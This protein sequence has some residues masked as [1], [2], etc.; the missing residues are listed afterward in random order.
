MQIGKIR[1]GGMPL[2]REWNALADRYNSGSFGRSGSGK[3]APVRI[4]GKNISGTD[5]KRFDCMAIEGVS[6]DLDADG[7]VDLV[8]ELQDGSSS[9]AT[10]ILVDPIE[11]QQ[12]GEIIV[13]GLAIAKVAAGTATHEYAI[14]SS[15]G[16]LTPQEETSD[17]R[18]LA[19]PSASVTTYLPVLLGVGAGGGDSFYLY[20]LTTVMGASTGTATI[21][22]LADTTEI[23]TG[24]SLSNTLGHF[25]GLA[26]GRRGICVKDGST[27]RAVTPYVVD[28][29]WQAPDLEQTKDGTNYTNIDTAVDCE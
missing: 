29:R 5:Y 11:D 8:F 14:A 27:Y 12:F 24:V 2:A 16:D 6:T 28:V 20:T 19:S 4:I 15:D 1:P 23:A 17:I 10:A 9:Q 22:N 26:S 3:R 18:L 7:N 25:T 21:R 13:D